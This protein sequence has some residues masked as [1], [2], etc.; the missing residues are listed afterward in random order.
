MK[1]WQIENSEAS[2]I[3]EI[4]FRVFDFALKPKSKT[5]IQKNS[6]KISEISR[7]SEV[8][9]FSTWPIYNSINI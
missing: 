4:F 3:S 5:Q 9:E 8:S 7:I 6:K 1:K 2:E